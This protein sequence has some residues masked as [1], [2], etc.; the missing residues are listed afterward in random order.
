MA[1]R[2]RIDQE[3]IPLD[4]PGSSAGPPRRSPFGWNYGEP[5]P[6]CPSTA[7]A[8]SSTSFGS[9]AWDD[10]GPSASRVGGRRRRSVASSR[11]SSLAGGSR[12]RGAGA[13]SIAS[14]AVRSSVLSME[15]ENERE[16][17]EA[18]E[19]EVLALR[20]QLAARQGAGR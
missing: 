8:S 15:L 3:V 5:V 2:H 10:L 11:S 12:L 4:R 7:G 19:Q 16:L 13:S 14:Q 9:S 18:A 1:W 20:A 17:R 6:E